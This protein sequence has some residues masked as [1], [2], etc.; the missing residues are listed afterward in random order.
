MSTK[1]QWC[2]MTRMLGV[3]KPYGWNGDITPN[4]TIL[5]THLTSDLG[6][7]SHQLFNPPHPSLKCSN[8]PLYIIY[9]YCISLYYIYT[10]SL[11]IIY[12]LYLSILYMY[13]ISLYYMLIMY[14]ISLYHI[15]TVSLYIIYVLYLS[16][17]YMYCISL[18]Y[19]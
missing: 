6:I 5:H 11:Y 13:C 7:I 1:Q 9:M 14:C 2:A 12:V 18:Y 3:S 15:Y 16:I 17:L 8:M 19:I 4:S 10:V